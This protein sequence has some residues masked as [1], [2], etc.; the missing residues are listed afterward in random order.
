MNDEGP[1]QPPTKVA[2]VEQLRALFGSSGP[3]HPQRTR[4]TIGRKFGKLIRNA[5]LP[6]EV[7]GGEPG[8]PLPRRWVT[9]HWLLDLMR[10]A[11]VQTTMLAKGRNRRRQQRW[12]AVV[13][14][15]QEAL[16]AVRRLGGVRAM[17]AMI[18]AIE[19]GRG[20]V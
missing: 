1:A 16:E 17:V 13:A 10:A 14:Q 18:D 20:N 8:N 9:E 4:P 2:T 7:E 19:H 15:H 3:R 6:A 5:G 11:D 12:L